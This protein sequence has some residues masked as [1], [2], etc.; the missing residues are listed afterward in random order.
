MNATLAGNLEA[1]TRTGVQPPATPAPFRLLTADADGDPRLR[2]PDGRT[3]RL[4]SA[5][6]PL[7]EAEALVKAALGSAPAPTAV[8]VIGAGT[9]AVLEVLAATPVA[10]ILV[11][12]PDPELALPW[13][14]RRSWTDLIL[15]DR[16]RL[17][18]GPDYLGTAHAARAIEGVERLPIVA[19]PVLAREYPDAMLAARV[20]LD[21]V[22]RDAAANANAR[23]RFEDL[24]F[25]N[26]I[27]NLPLLLREADAASLAGAFQGRPAIVLG[28]GPSLDANVEA[29]RPLR[30]SCL[31]VAADTAVVPC[32]KGGLTPDLA[33]ALDP[34]LDNARHLTRIAVPDS[35]HLVCEAS[36]DPSVPRA[37][38]GRT[39]FF[40][41]GRHAPWPWLESVGISLGILEAWGS[42][43]TSALD[44]A[45]RAGCSPILF[46]GLDLAFTRGQ[47]Y[48]R[49]TPLDDLWTWR[50]AAGDR[51]EDL[52]AA[53]RTARP[54]V[55]ER[56]IEGGD[57]PTAAHLIA[58]RDWIRW[59]PE[60]ETW[61]AVR[62]PL[63]P[64][65]E[66]GWI[67][68]SEITAHGDHLYLIERDN[69]IGEAA[70]VKQIT[71]VSLAGLA[72][73]PLGGD[74]PL[75]RKEV[76][77]DLLPDLAAPHGYIVDKV[78]GFTIDAAGNAFVVTDNDGTD[79]S[80]GETHFLPLGAL[81]AM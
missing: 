73:A 13:L 24:A 74:L 33:V 39:F 28:A 49:H 41:V 30:S 31:V 25:R 65:P 27:A 67:G 58:F 78:E 71:R 50:V 22:V 7:A 19:H 23:G 81:E 51:L 60:A 18:V 80:S 40:R 44:L 53:H 15:A 26:T 6:N 69:Q 5:R 55:M 34:S 20:A 57:T 29:L 36:V 11:F 32:V 47:T 63:D 9:G 14:S 54:V 3:V 2:T 21:R 56:A 42:V 43:V 16:L 64:A 52:W 37:F 17:L 76:V 61:S 66:G 35:V 79:D 72:P 38:A 4:G 59:D 62:Y 10:R 75:V 77:R 68:L 1:L 46:A 45:V 8:A 70:K 48:C 12:E